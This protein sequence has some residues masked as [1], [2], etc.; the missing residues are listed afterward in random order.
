MTEANFLYISS[1]CLVINASKKSS[2]WSPED[3]SSII[4]WLYIKTGSY[5]CFFNSFPSLI[6]YFWEKL[7]WHHQNVWLQRNWQWFSSNYVL[8]YDAINDN[9]LFYWDHPMCVKS[10]TFPL[11][12]SSLVLIGNFNANIVQIS[13]LIESGKGKIC[14]PQRL[15]NAYEI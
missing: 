7:M 4:W 8:F 6:L 12:L 14:F 3:G 1:C 11:I 9:I 2:F 10:P 13:D 15:L 5:V